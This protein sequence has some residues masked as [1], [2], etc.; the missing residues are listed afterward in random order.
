VDSHTALHIRQMT[1]NYAMVTTWEL[2][3]AKKIPFNA[4][5]RSKTHKNQSFTYKKQVNPEIEKH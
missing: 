1:L 2:E 3:H 4:K 5:T